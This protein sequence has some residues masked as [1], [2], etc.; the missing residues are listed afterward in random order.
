[1]PSASIYVSASSNWQKARAEAK[2]YFDYAERKRIYE[3]QLKLAKSES[4]SKVFL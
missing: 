1:M 4:R 3:R 2:F